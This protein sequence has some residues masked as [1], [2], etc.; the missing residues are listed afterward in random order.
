MRKECKCLSQPGNSNEEMPGVK[1]CGKMLGCLELEKEHLYNLGISLLSLTCTLQA[2]RILQGVYQG[3]FALVAES[4]CEI[5]QVNGPDHGTSKLVLLK[6]L[7]LFKGWGHQESFYFLRL[8]A[9]LKA[10][11]RGWPYL[12][13]EAVNIVITNPLS[14]LVGIGHILRVIPCHSGSFFQ[15]GADL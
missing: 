13:S 5:I 3:E 9:E 7:S 8:W 2:K 11:W 12:D 1:G 4:A 6:P 10:H 15:E 14:A